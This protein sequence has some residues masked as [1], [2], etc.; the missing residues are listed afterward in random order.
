MSKTSF[1]CTQLIVKFI[2]ICYIKGGFFTEILVEAM[3]SLNEFDISTLWYRIYDSFELC[4]N[5]WKLNM[6]CE[7]LVIFK[8]KSV[9]YKSYDEITDALLAIRDRLNAIEKE[10]KENQY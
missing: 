3:A 2:C 9:L 7:T 6:P 4:Q 8:G 1:V 5:H 10:I